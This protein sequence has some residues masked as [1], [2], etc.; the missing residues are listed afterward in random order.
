MKWLPIF[1]V[2]LGNV[3]YHLGQRSVPAG[4]NPVVATLAA[5]LIAIVMTL[6]TVPFLARDVAWRSALTTLNSAT[7][8]V[9]LGAV[10]VEIGFLLVYRAGWSV[11]NASVTANAVLSVVLLGIGV[12][13]FREPASATRVLG[14]GVCLGGLW[15]VTRPA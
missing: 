6:A 9:A 2:V 13:A 1:V 15:L 4:A 10:L 12:L 3:F 5:Y 8:F 14:V 7:I 11:S